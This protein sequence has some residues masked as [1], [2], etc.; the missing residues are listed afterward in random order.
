M[1]AGSGAGDEPKKH[2]QIPRSSLWDRCPGIG[3][4]GD[5]ETGLMNVRLDLVGEMLVLSWHGQGHLQ[6]QLERKCLTVIL[7]GAE[8]DGSPKAV[9]GT[10]GGSPYWYNGCP[11][12]VLFCRWGRDNRQPGPESRPKLLLLSCAS[13]PSSRTNWR[14]PVKIS[15]RC[16]HDA[17]KLQRWNLARLRLKPTDACTMTSQPF[18]SGLRQYR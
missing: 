6:R 5:F 12:C 7:D 2:T 9:G 1:D 11:S 13:Y 10:H 15:R 17:E 3:G 14:A 16:A 4:G 8:G 18:R